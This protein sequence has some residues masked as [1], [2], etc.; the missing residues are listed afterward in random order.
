MSVSIRE[1]TAAD[2]A[3]LRACFI[4]LQDA[5]REFE[6]RLRP[7]ADIAEEYY[8]VVLERCAKYAG[9]IFLAQVD[10]EVA[11]YTSVLTHVPY[12]DL[13]DPPGEHAYLWDLYVHERY[14]GQGIARALL[15]HAEAHARTRGATELRINVL[16]RN[17]PARELYR[18]CGFDPHLESLNKAL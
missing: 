1:F 7:G 4:G 8:G 18:S 11:G 14:R 9:T 3:A 12:E 17:T 15:A 16:A 13:D 10:G 5:E 6:P 2:A